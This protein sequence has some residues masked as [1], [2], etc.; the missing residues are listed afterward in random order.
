MGSEHTNNKRIAKNTL[1]LYTRMLL[2][3][4]L[5]L[6]TSRIVLQALGV[7]DYGI[8]SLVGGF[9]AMLAYMN[10]VF[11]SA[12]QRFISYA[13]GNEDSKNLH[14]VFCTSVT[15]HYILAILILI[16]AETFGLWFINTHLNIEPG[17]LEAA[18]WVF[19]CSVLSLMINIISI[20]YNAC[21]IAHEH[22]KIYAYVS[23]FEAFAKI[24]NVYLLMVFPFDKLIQYAIYSLVISMI[25]RTIYVFY[26][27]K[28][29]EEC[30]YQYY[31]D[32]SLFKKMA[33]YAGWTAV[34]TL[35]FTFKDQTLNIILNLFYNTAVNAAR[36]IAV[37]VS[38]MVNQ[39]ASNFFLAVTPQITKRYA[40]GDIEGT[41]KLVYTS[42]KFAF[43]MLGLLTIPLCLNLRYLLELWLGVVPEYTYEFIIVILIST[44]I[45][46]FASPVTNAI[47][48]TGNIRNFQIGICLI[49]IMEIPLAYILLKN[50]AS[51]YVALCPSIATQFIGVLFRFYLL[52]KQVSG[53]SFR[54]YLLR[55]VLK[56]LL[57][58]ALT[59][60]C[61]YYFFN[62]YDSGLAMLLISTLAS[63]ILT[64]VVI[65]IGGLEK[66]ER[67]TID[68]YLKKMFKLKRNL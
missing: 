12:S 42:A 2:L 9:V 59:Y 64:S 17:R 20:P 19:Q 48:A 63:L 18:N 39:F 1:F 5:G 53:Y 23:I 4:V 37:S 16:I 28:H 10:S 62:R 54:Y 8:Y 41:Q 27:K 56:S 7:S 47:Q 29:F 61:L 51:P 68:T 15:V 55:I 11:V 21:I 3:M 58:L 45:A 52:K 67:K 49:F 30:K 66:Q 35:G 34:G 32:K 22:M 43:F 33:N 46:S 36:G 57:L 14:N 50:G 40:K 6:Y 13:L 25:V 24:L 65:Y 31:I 38:G 44:L 60:S 26:C